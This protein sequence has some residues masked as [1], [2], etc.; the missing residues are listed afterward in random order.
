[1]KK[2]LCALLVLP[3]L[4][5][6]V[7]TPDQVN[8]GY[9]L[10]SIFQTI[11]TNYGPLSF[12]EQ[13]QKMNWERRKVKYREKLVQLSNTRDYYFMIADLLH[14]FNDAHVSITLPS[15]YEKYLP[16]NFVLAENKAIVSFYQKTVTQAQK[17]QLN[18]GDELVGLNGFALDVVQKSSPHFNAKGNPLTSRSLF[19]RELSALRESSGIDLLK[20]PYLKGDK[21]TLNLIDTKTNR[22]KDCSLQFTQG[23]MS[24]VSRPIDKA[25][26]SIDKAEETVSGLENS[27]SEMNQNSPEISPA[28]TSVLFSPSE[29]ERLKRLAQISHQFNDLNNVSDPNFFTTTKNQIAGDTE[30]KHVQLGHRLPLWKM[31]KNFKPIKGARFKNPVNLF[32]GTFQREGKKVGYLR[33]PNYLPNN[34]F[35]SQ[36]AIRRI[37]RTLEEKSD[38]LIIDQIDNPGGVLIYSDLIIK[39]LV[40]E[41]DDKKHLNFV[42]KPTQNYLRQ[43]LSAIQNM[44]ADVKTNNLLSE[45]EKNHFMTELSANFMRVNQAFQTHA[46]L[47][48]PVSQKIIAEYLELSIDRSLSENILI[49]SLVK[50][51]FGKEAFKNLPYTKPTVM[52]INELDVS[53]GDS[54]PAVLK[55]YGRV[56]LLGVR[57]CGA[58]GIVE[59]FSNNAYNSFD[60][61]LTT[62]LMLRKDNYLL[63]N[64][65]VQPDAP[66]ELTVEDYKSQFSGTLERL[67]KTA[68]TELSIPKESITS[69]TDEEFQEVDR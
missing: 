17:C 24:I 56:K 62:S 69:S 11:E 36:F 6:A 42:V 47:T 53:G 27:F 15:T 2:L 37:M 59:S 5:F 52:L 67:V 46:D 28:N 44:M 29:R 33:I 49:R 25:E 68:E 63:E 23:G 61:R 19:I 64:F 43:Y 45:G 3:G 16:V 20:N 51:N 34:L 60:Y 50:F 26:P 40:G 35:L 38:Y 57:T 65:G 32:A 12:K 58:G 7:L 21:V 39:G 9:E 22:Q 14:E 8:L 30:G 1:M 10:E 4:C 66:F 31:P 13:F 55:D 48:A 54:T 18:I 41:Y